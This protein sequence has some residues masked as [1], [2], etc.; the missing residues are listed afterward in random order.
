MSS[1]DALT[2]PASPTAAPVIAGA[3]AFATTATAALSAGVPMEWMLIGAA[4]LPDLMKSIPAQRA[5]N[6]ANETIR[7]LRQEIDDHHVQMDRWSDQQ[8]QFVTS[9]VHTILA[10]GE[11]EKL[12]YLQRAA[13]NVAMNDAVVRV[14]GAFLARTL[15]DITAQEL[16]YLV[17]N[18]RRKILLPEHELTPDKVASNAELAEREGMAY[19]VSDD[20]REIVTGLQTLGLLRTSAKRWAAVD[21]DWS[22]TAGKILTLVCPP[23][24]AMAA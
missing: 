15:R 20:E 19:A 11:A 9:M 6:K 8:H 12:E 13:M 14:G 3:A 4:M 23:P 16:T 24:D 10:T 22:A 5:A 21:L 1:L 2:D 18:F 17:I 7:K